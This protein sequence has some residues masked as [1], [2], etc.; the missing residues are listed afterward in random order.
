MAKGVHVLYVRTA[1]PWRTHYFRKAFGIGGSG[2]A[3]VPWCTCSVL[4]VYRR[5]N[6]DATFV[7]LY[8]YT[9]PFKFL[10]VLRFNVN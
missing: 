2:G 1:A 7:Q 10:F 5:T 8:S 4:C 9:S 6:C 3:V